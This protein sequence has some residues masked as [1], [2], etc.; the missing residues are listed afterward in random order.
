MF[1]CINKYLIKKICFFLQ[2]GNRG[3]SVARNVPLAHVFALVQSR[4]PPS[5]V[6]QAVLP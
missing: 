2:P 5:M 3:V 6:G 4:E 1:A